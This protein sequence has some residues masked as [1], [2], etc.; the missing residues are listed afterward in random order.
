[1]PSY[2]Q[3]NPVCIQILRAYTGM[4]D[5][6]T[7]SPGVLRKPGDLPKVCPRPKKFKRLATRDIL[8]GSRP[9][10]R[11]R[12]PDGRIVPTLSDVS[13]KSAR[14]KTCARRKTKNN[15][16]AYTYT[17]MYMMDGSWVDGFVRV[18]CTCAYFFVFSPP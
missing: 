6:E 3:K 14:T 18:V 11:Q 7:Q 9:N 12:H 15:N 16:Y 10:L 4:G 2:E 8:H 1:M 13:D 5:A 17:Y